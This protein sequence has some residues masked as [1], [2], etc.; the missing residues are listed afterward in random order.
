[1]MKYLTKEV[2]GS[3][4]L[5]LSNSLDT[6]PFDHGLRAWLEFRVYSGG[7]FT[8]T[9][10]LKQRAVEVWDELTLE[11]CRTWCSEFKERMETVVAANGGQAKLRCNTTLDS[12]IRNY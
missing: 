7:G 12:V 4:T 6:N 8:S 5:R 2:S 11:M 1:M 10:D 9:D 3:V